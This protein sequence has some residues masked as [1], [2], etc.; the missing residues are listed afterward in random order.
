MEMGEEHRLPIQ[1]EEQFLTLDPKEW[2]KLFNDVLG[3]WNGWDKI[4]IEHWLP[5]QW[6]E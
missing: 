6:E 5:I 1:R 3:G 2:W 4:G